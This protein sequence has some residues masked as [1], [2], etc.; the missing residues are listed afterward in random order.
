MTANAERFT[1]RVADYERY[2]TRYPQRVIETLRE[3]CGLRREDVVADVGAGT[4]MLAELFLENGNAV[5]AVEPNA[6]MRAAC[7]RILARYERL[8]VVDAAAEHTELDASSVDMVAVG[9][10]FHWFDRDRALAE[11]KRILKPGGWV[12]L[13]A[14]RRAHDGSEQAK[15]YEAILI[16]HGIDYARVRGGYRNWEGM[17]PYGD[18]EVF[19]AQMPGEQRLTLEEFLGQTQSLSV[20]P[21]P[22][23]AKYEGMQ[24]AL[25]EF[26]AKWSDG[27]VLRLE[28]VCSVAGWRTPL[29]D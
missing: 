3:R 4:G 7:E 6:E 14:N 21:M 5:I 24:R 26:F 2:R 18:A 22:W 11:F 25:K 16:E 28:T 20:I 17:K 13:A 12:V 10:A 9:R 27:K 23:H 8:R 1:G 15:E 29:N 19:K